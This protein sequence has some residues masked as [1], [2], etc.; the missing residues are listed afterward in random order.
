MAPADPPSLKVFL[1]HKFKAPAINQF[2][3]RLFS[4]AHVQFEVDKGQ[5]AI[6]VTRLERKIRDG[7]GF[8][9]IH[10]Y[11]NDGAQEVSDIEL[12]ERSKYFRLELELAAR[13]RKPGMVLTD[14][15][16]RGVIDVPSTISSEQFD[17]RE[18]AGAGEKPTSGRFL[19]AFSGFCERVRIASLYDVNFGNP[20]RES[21]SV[22]LLLPA[23]SA[24]GYR[25]EDIDAVSN[26][27]ARR[28]TSRFFF[29]GRRRLLPDGSPTS[30]PSTGS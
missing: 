12:L 11:D 9:A 23:G 21:W 16:F 1:S 3:F 5:F 13:S 22:G 19:K 29:P 28:V 14:Q 15:R 17:A 18:I 25:A 24:N 10:S 2:F 30:L 4:Q 7:D 26:G 20:A 6:N 27:F 8:L